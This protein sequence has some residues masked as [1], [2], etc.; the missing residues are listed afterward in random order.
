MKH[1]FAAT[2][3]RTIVQLIANPAAGGHDSRKIAALH[4]AFE[5]AGAE[6]I[7]S[8]CG[9]RQPIEVDRRAGHVCIVGG[10]G[11]VRHAALAAERCGRPVTLSFYPAGTVNLLHREARCDLDPD[12]YAAR[13]IGGDGR[14]SHYAASL[15]D[16][17]FLACASVGPDSAAVAALSPRLKRRIGRLAYGVAFLAVLLKWPRPDIRLRSG[18]RTIDCEAFYIAKGRYFAGPWTFA[19]EARGDDPRL[20][21]VTLGKATRWRYLRFVLA[22]LAGSRIDRLPGVICF[23]CTELTAECAVPFPVQAD[24]DTAA[25]LP[26]T[27]RLRPDPFEFH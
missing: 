11:T 21:V 12:I 15:N 23:D 27:I 25:S 13:I 6:V 4:A 8:E 19:P 7:P 22:M 14:R 2:Q 20:H 18:E 24:G 17:L 1:A 3:S 26:V 5:R 16:S 9:P 10:D